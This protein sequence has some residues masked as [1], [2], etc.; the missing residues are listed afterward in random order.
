MD[1]GS[2][3]RIGPLS[4]KNLDGKVPSLQTLQRDHEPARKT[5]KKTLERY[6]RKAP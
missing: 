4:L 2:Y 3:E 5:A 1:E 6:F